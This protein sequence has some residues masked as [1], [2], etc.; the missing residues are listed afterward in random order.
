MKILP[1]FALVVLVGIGVGGCVPQKNTDSSRSLTKEEKI[2]VALAKL[3]PE[4]RKLAE[5][6]KFC[7]VHSKTRLGS[8]DKPIKIMINGQAVFLCCDGCEKEANDNQQA[9]L[10]KVKELTAANK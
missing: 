9:T 2:E 4:D 1:W 3:S 5:A 10:A 8:M 7:A 6:Q